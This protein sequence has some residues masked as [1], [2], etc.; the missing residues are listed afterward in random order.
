MS[1]SNILKRAKTNA[2]FNAILYIIVGAV[3]AIYPGVAADLLCYMLGGVLLLCGLVDII[4]FLF[5]RDG[6]VYSAMRMVIGITLAAVGIWVMFQPKLIFSVVPWIVGG[7]IVV[8]ALQDL[9]YAFQMM[10][11]HAPRWAGALLVAAVTLAL[12]VFLI[13]SAFETAMLAVRII[14]IFLLVDGLSDLWLALQVRKMHQKLIADAAHA[15]N[16]VDVDYTEISEEPK[17]AET[18]ENPE[19]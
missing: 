1:D 13:V 14:G 16:A 15:A 11:N 5:R 3:L 19:P 2:A 7:L 4:L 17:P 10:K 18:D 6:S 12:G 8:H 9:R